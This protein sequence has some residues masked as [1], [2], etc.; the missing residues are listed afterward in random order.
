MEAEDLAVVVRELDA[1]GKHWQLKK[2]EES[3]L[4]CSVLE[5]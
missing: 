1:S 5:A 4:A 2:A 3:Q